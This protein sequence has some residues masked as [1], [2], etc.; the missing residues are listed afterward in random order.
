MHS[1]IK[2]SPK[3]L[4]HPWYQKW[5][6]GALH[7]EALQVYA[8]EYYWQVANFPRYLSRLHSQIDDLKTRQVILSNLL[9]EENSSKPHPELWL[10][11]ADS[12]GVD[13]QKVRSSR[14]GEPAQALVGEFQA[15][16]NSS[17][18]EGL[19]A[20][21]AYESQVPE[22]AQFKEKALREFYLDKSVAD[23]GVEFFAVHREADVWHTQQLEEIVASLSEEKREKAQRAADRACAAL[24]KFLDSMPGAEV[25]TNAMPN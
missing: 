6:C 4:S 7:K 9:D 16:V 21:M 22:V 3:L 2:I 15:L 20:I 12:L 13:T 10:N 24:W 8:S 5:E 17:P 1:S 18:E 23:R 11:F 19:G 14:P 25:K